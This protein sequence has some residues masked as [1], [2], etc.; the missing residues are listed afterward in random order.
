MKMSINFEKMN[1]LENGEHQFRMKNVSST[2]SSTED[3]ASYLG[4]KM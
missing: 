4:I 2:I 3:L 1:I